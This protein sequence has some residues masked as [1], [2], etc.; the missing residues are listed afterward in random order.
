[1]QM[2]AAPQSA[3]AREWT[4]VLR[5]KRILIVDDSAANRDVLKRHAASWGMLPRETPSARE[6]LDWV[7]RGDPF[8]VA[9]LDMQM[10]ELDGVM[11]AREIQ[12]H[13]GLETFPL[14]LLSS[15]GRRREDLDINVAFAGH[16]TKPIKASQLYEMLVK[17]L[18]TNS[19][20]AA[21]ERA[22][23]PE[24]DGRPAARAPL[25]IL[26]AEDNAV[27]QRLALLLLEKLGYSADVAANGVEA[28]EAV[29]S[30]RYDVVLMDVEMPDVDG[31]EATRR[32]HARNQNG[33]PPRII[34]VTANAMQGDRDACLAAGM[35]DYLSKPIRLEE[36]DAALRC[37]EPRG[38]VMQAA[39]PQTTDVLDGG[40]LKQLRA[41]GGPEFLAE[42]AATFLAE[43]PT[44]IATLR[45]ARV[46]GDVQELR[47]GAHT[48]KANARTF[49]AGELAGAC[50]RLETLAAAG[51]LNG[52]AELVERIAAEYGRAAAA[53]ETIGA[54][55]T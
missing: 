5:G 9:L 35:D 22:P 40:A 52:A 13:V 25:R 34:A 24:R 21:R 49:G 53:L 45:G 3:I 51:V 41:M 47:R 2:E 31:L 46:A 11:L 32:I 8:D 23:S 38:A 42:L 54:D 55:A 10:P 30:R 26:V 20:A 28:V 43:A 19:G 44:L 37:C 36:L 48:L 50:Q 4:D 18:G 39:A 6:A 1:M 15:L 14:V 29:R 33:P 12:R 7:L 17:V 16:L 27:N